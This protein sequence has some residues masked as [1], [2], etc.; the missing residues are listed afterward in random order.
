[1]KVSASNSMSVVA[2]V[3]ATR[4]SI[5]VAAAFE[6]SIQP[7]SMITRTGSLSV[8]S[9]PAKFGEMRYASLIVRSV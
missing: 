3:S 6:V 4:A 7:E 5:A 2:P 1:M 8:G 9:A